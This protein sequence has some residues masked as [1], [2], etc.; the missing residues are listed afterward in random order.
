MVIEN[1]IPDRGDLVWL[2][3]NPQSGNSSRDNA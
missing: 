1:Y 2:Q 3:F